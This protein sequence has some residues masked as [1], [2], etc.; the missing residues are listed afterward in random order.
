LAFEYLSSYWV[1]PEAQASPT[2]TAPTA[3]SDVLYYPKNVLVQGLRTAFLKSK[4]LPTAVAVALDYETILL[5]AIASDVPAPILNMGGE[6]RTEPLISINNLP[7][8][9]YGV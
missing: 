5:D 2:L 7:D 4:S 1:K 6:A 8:S 9:G 3:N